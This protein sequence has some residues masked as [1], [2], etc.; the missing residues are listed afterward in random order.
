MAHK[1]MEMSSN[2]SQETIDTAHSMI[3]ELEKMIE[4]GNAPS[5]GKVKKLNDLL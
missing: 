2:I 5:E 1:S 4:A 3:A